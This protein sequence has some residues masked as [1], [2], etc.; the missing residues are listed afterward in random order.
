MCTSSPLNGTVSGP[1][2]QIQAIP[3]APEPAKADYASSLLGRKSQ[4]STQAQTQSARA[5]TILTSARGLLDEA[6]TK[7]KTL[8]GQ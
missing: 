1:K 8:L 4:K 7:R 2:E 3:P 6:P 5:S